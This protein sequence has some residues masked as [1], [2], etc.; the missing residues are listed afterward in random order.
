M[1]SPSIDYGWARLRRVE[2]KMVLKVIEDSGEIYNGNFRSILESGVE[3]V[4]IALDLFENNLELQRKKRVAI[5]SALE[6]GINYDAQ[7]LEINRRLYIHYEL[8]GG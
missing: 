6:R 2:G 7:T 3:N 4:L 8:A 5:Q 1:T